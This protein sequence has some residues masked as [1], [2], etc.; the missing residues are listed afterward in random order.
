MPWP[1]AVETHARGYKQAAE[2]SE[3]PWACPV[4][5]SRLK[6]LSNRSLSFSRKRKPASH[7]AVASAKTLLTYIIAASVSLHG[8]WPWHHSELC[9]RYFSLVR[10]D[11]EIDKQFRR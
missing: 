2:L 4:E 11:H 10:R 7:K 9:Y 5:F 6:A 8:A 1:C 3:M